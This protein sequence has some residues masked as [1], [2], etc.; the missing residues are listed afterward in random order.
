MP[1]CSTRLNEFVLVKYSK[2]PAEGSYRGQMV[3]NYYYY[4]L[5]LRVMEIDDFC[6]AL[7]PRVYPQVPAQCAKNI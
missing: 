5:P 1:R 2:V 4:R 6:Y 7:S 3:I